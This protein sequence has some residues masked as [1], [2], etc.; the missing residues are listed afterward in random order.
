MMNLLKKQKDAVGLSVFTNKLEIHTPNKTTKRHHRILY[1]ELDKL[2][3]N[4]VISNDFYNAC[5]PIP[6][7]IFKS[8]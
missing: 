8:F 2:L 3:E 1:N 6:D 7:F 4:N 5:L